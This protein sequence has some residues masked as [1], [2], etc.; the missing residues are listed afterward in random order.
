MLLSRP[1]RPL[2]LLGT[3]A[4]AAVVLL[5]TAPAPAQQPANPVIPPGTRGYQTTMIIQNHWQHPAE[6]PPPPPAARPTRVAPAQPLQVVVTAPAE[7]PPFYVN[8]RG[9]DGQVRRFPVEGGRAAIRVRE[10][11]VRPGQ[12]VTVYVGSPAGHPKQ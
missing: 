12:T 7:A 1:F 9:P 2:S 3:L 6:L 5:S 10:I 11:I 4:A 8:L